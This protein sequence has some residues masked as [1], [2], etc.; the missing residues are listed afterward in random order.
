MGDE[1]QRRTPARHPERSTPVIPS[2]ARDLHLTQPADH[3]SGIAKQ[4]AAFRPRYPRELFDYL[5]SIVANHRRAWDCGAGSG[6]ATLDLAERFDEVIATDLSDKQLARAPERPNI[7]WLVAP[8]ESV[9]IESET[10]D[11][12]TVA[13]ALH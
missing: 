3:F 12:T 13:Q 2:E 9:P 6:Q 8:A 10:V 1:R 5:A 11:L 4:Y 7:T